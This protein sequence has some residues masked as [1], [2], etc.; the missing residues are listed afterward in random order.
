MYKLKEKKI[1][2]VASKDAIHPLPCMNSMPRGLHMGTDTP[3]TEE[4]FQA[5]GCAGI[6]LSGRN[7]TGSLI[8][9]LNDRWGH[10]APKQREEVTV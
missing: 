8:W 1:L 7:L 9:P 10:G 4:S 3:F 6:M 2:K 5:G